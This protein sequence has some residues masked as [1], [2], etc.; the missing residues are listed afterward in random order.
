MKDVV[1][2][3]IVKCLRKNK[4]VFAWTLQDLEGIDPGVITHHLNIDSNVKPVKQKKLHFGPKKDKIIQAEVN[5]LLA[6]GHIKEIQFPD[7]L[8][9]V[10]IVPKHEEKWRM[11]IDFRDLNKA[12]PKNFYPLPR[13][14][15]FVDSTS[16]CEL[17][18]ASQ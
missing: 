13:I 10:V 8:S 7:W 11:C 3:E 9:N 14:D 15:Q 6:A 5:K 18:D 1:L 17:M 2:E 4:D 16:G 12:C